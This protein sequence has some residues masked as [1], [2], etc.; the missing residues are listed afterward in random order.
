[1]IFIQILGASWLERNTTFI[2]NHILDLVANPKAASSH[3]DAVYSRKCINFILRSIL[4]RMLSEKAQASTCKQLA[5]IVAKQM[6]TIGIISYIFIL[7][8]VQFV[9]IFFC[10]D[11]SPENAKDSNQETLF[12]QHL[13]VCALQEMGLL[14]LS[15]GTTANN[16]ISDPSC[17]EL[18]GS[19]S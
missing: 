4:G 1:M 17:G 3:I 6:A 12:G 11:F 13:L 14:M 5:I 7:V 19:S 16:L 9:N 10:I 15:L 2:L 8:V 18:S